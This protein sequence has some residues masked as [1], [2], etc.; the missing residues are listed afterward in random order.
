MI[1]MVEKNAIIKLDESVKESEEK[2]IKWYMNKLPDF[3]END[4]TKEKVVCFG[5]SRDL[6]DIDLQIVVAKNGL[7]YEIETC[8]TNINRYDEQDLEYYER[9]YKSL[10]PDYKA[11]WK[12]L[13]TKHRA[14]LKETKKMVR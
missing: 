14:K 5:T 8:I 7:L 4:L 11:F 6:Q 10:G 13:I 3:N 12:P 1:I 9:A 2:I